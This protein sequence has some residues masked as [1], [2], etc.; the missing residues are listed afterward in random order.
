MYTAAKGDLVF[1]DKQDPKNPTKRV[2]GHVGIYIGD[3]KI[4]DASSSRNAVVLRDLWGL[5]SNSSGLT[6]VGYAH[7]W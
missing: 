6:V 2:I 3:N 4:I 1:W 7:P 5:M